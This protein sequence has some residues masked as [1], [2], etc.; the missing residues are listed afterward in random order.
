MGCCSS[1]D[2]TRLKANLSE[3]ESDSETGQDKSDPVFIEDYHILYLTTIQRRQILNHW[4]RKFIPSEQTPDEIIALFI[5]FSNNPFENCFE[6]KVGQKVRYQKN[7]GQSML[8]AVIAECIIGCRVSLCVIGDSEEEVGLIDAAHEELPSDKIFPSSLGEIDAMN[9]KNDDWDDTLLLVSGGEV[10]VRYDVPKRYL[11]VSSFCTTILEG[12]SEAISMEV[13]QV[14]PHYLTMIVKYM[15]HY[16]GCE[17]VY[18]IDIDSVGDAFED[19][20]TDEWLV[21][22][23]KCI[24]CMDDG[25]IGLFLAANY[26]DIL[27]LSKVCILK[28]MLNLK[29]KSKEEAMKYLSDNGISTEEPI[30]FGYSASES[31]VM[32]REWIDKWCKQE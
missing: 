19:T 1:R 29:V 5:N 15:Y 6:F 8:Q 32:I 28:I 10:P 18:N 23:I 16:K 11:E 21:E 4:L 27:V 13:R 30:N 2:H 9:P 12:D 31:S 22:F 24:E 17:G 25:V 3:V 20:I 14:S 26:M 7:S